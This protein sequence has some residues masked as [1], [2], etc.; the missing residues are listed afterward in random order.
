MKKISRSE[1]ACDDDMLPHYDFTGGVRGKHYKA[2][3]RGYIIKIHK[4]DG[5]T[6]IKKIRCKLTAK[7]RNKKLR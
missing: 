5:T 2:R 4:R 6:Q 3:L 1:T 7:G